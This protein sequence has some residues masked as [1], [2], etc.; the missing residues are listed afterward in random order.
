MLTPQEAGMSL[1][2][3]PV[4]SL[5]EV[6][7]ILEVFQLNNACYPPLLFVYCRSSAKDFG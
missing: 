3:V 6:H 1:G 4:T 5:R 2:R 7:G